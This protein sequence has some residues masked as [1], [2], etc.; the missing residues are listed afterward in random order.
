[1]KL[2]LL[3]YSLAT[4]SNLFE[5]LGWSWKGPVFFLFFCF[6]IF[7]WFFSKSFWFQGFFSLHLFSSSS[8]VVPRPLALPLFLFPFVLSSLAGAA[9][10]AA[11]AAVAGAS[12]S[13]WLG[14]C[15]PACRLFFL[16]YGTWGDV[17]SAG[18]LP[19]GLLPGGPQPCKGDSRS[20]TGCARIPRYMRS[21]RGR[22]RTACT[23]WRGAYPPRGKGHN[24]RWP[25]SRGSARP[26]PAE[27]KEGALE[28]R[29]EVA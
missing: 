10:A 11:A 12:L 8:I 13:L 26:R 6:F 18:L 20:C 23:G 29:M 4:E 7:F 5:K 16:F 22:Y 2:V 3:F 21:T 14:Q 1:M 27:H 17:S 25:G 15:P 9:A 19:G 28:C 24:G